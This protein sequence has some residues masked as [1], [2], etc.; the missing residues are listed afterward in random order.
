MPT[1]FKSLSDGFYT[2][3]FEPDSEKR[4]D[5]INS[6][7]KESTPII[8][9]AI[10]N[11][12]MLYIKDLLDGTWEERGWSFRAKKFYGEYH[13]SV[14]KKG[15]P[16]I[17][18]IDAY[19]LQ[20]SIKILRS[21]AKDIYDTVGEITP[22][23]RAKTNEAIEKAKRVIDPS[24]PEAIREINLHENHTVE[25][26]IPLIKDFLEECYQN[27]VR[28]VR[29]IHGK[30]I[31]VLRQAVKELL[32]IHR[33]I[34]PESIVSADKDHGGEGATEANLVEFVPK[35]KESASKVMDNDDT[36]DD[37]DKGGRS[38]NDDRSDS[39]NPNNDSYH[40]AM[41]NYS[42]QMNPNND[43]YWSSRGR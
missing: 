36:D 35:R 1:I 42:N 7:I 28:R 17:P 29:I 20:L 18:F 6:W 11:E 31:G 10:E 30:G 32:E 40:A 22:E 3:F 41:D 37:Y 19:Q 43:A 4:K 25:E 9:S 14:G 12:L 38:P 21:S 39:M 16:N 34:I 2:A 23:I 27:G 13:P 24:P 15:S 33:Y 8:Q 26:A 5:E